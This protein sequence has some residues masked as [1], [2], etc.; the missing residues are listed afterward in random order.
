MNSK[1]L[2]GYKVSLVGLILFSLYFGTP[3]LGVITF[4]SFITETLGCSDF[5]HFGKIEPCFLLG[6]DIS[7]RFALY[8]IPFA[9][10]LITPLAYLF[11]F[12]ELIILWATVI[13]F[14]KYMNFRENKKIVNK[15]KNEKASE[16]GS[17]AAETRRPF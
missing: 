5:F 7:P 3:F 8:K 6:Y 4:R 2:I 14:F 16:A 9:N 11:A 15:F 13:V 17:D 1:W 12:V 10:A